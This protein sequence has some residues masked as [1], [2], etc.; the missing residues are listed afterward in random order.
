[1]TYVAGVKLTGP[2]SFMDLL[3]GDAYPK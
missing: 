2:M 3:I 1:M